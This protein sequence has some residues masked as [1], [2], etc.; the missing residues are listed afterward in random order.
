MQVKFLDLKAVNAPYFEEMM[1][2]TRRFFESGWYVLG[3]E[4]SSFEKEYAAYCGSEYCVGVS[5]GLDALRLILEGYKALGLLHEG[6]EVIVPAN[7]YIASILAITQ[8]R[9][10]PVLAEPDKDSYNIDQIGR[11]HV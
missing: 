10:T 7:T 5:N 6:D 1:E 2:A 9:L 4:V 3:N 8:S 11:A